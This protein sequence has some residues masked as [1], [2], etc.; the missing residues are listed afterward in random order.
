MQRLRR[1]VVFHYQD[2][3]NKRK[4]CADKQGKYGYCLLKSLV[5]VIL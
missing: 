4:L 3:P 5:T 1:I 2:I